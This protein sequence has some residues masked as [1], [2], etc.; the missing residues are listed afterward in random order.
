MSELKGLVKRVRKIMRKDVVSGDA[1]RIE[2]LVWMFF[3]KVYDELKESNEYELE[4]SDYKS[5]IPEKYRWRNWAIDHKDGKA[6]TGDELVS[7]INN[8]LFPALKDLHVD[9]NTPKRS[10]IVQYVFSRLHNYM[11]NGTLI[12]QVLNEL[13][14]NIDFDKYEDRHLFNEIYESILQELQNAG[15][16]GEFYTPRPI[17]DFMAEI[18]DPKPGEIIADFAC[19]TGGFLVSAINHMKKNNNSQHA[20]DSIQENVIGCEFKPLP[21]LLCVTNMLLHDLDG[22]NITY[23]SSLSRN[24]YDYGPNDQVDVVLMNPPFGGEIAPGE[25]LNFPKLYR[26]SETANLFICL[27]LYRL[28][29]EGR[30]AIVLPDS[31]LTT[32]SEQAYV[33]LKKKLMKECNLHTIV[34]LPTGLF[35]AN[36]ATNILFFE[37]GKETNGIWY[38]KVPLPEGYRSFSKT[39]P[40]TNEHLNGVRKWWNNRENGDINA[41]FVTQQQI[42]DNNYNIDIKNPNIKDDKP[43][44]SAEQLMS[45]IGDNLGKR[46]EAFGRIQNALKNNVYFLNEEKVE[47]LNNDFDY[48]HMLRLKVIEHFMFDEEKTDKWE[49]D[50]FVNACSILDS[51]RKPITKSDRKKGEYPYY[52][53]NGIQDYVDGYLFDGEF[54]LIGEDGSVITED[55]KPIV[56]LASGKIWVNNHAHIV[57]ENG[58]CLLKYLYYYL[59]NV[60]ITKYAHGNIPKFTQGDLKQLVIKYP[61]SLSEQREIIQKIAYIDYLIDIM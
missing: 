47:K 45:I 44:Y 54:L 39:K 1:Q 48:K 38:Y 22:S 7:F 32:N 21:Y 30:V 28:K 52:G 17:T 26:T 6:L 34:R 25:D 33:E 36:I 10:A 41:Y 55:G 51:R 13:N 27:V 53:A 18:M 11:V 46:N 23:G 31:F 35:Y 42:I 2:Q 40:F 50:T 49:S 43:E 14:E 29:K 8:E 19:G 56:N 5:I 9:E 57:E 60:D 4:S 16:A 3:L 15:S 59:Q 61:K 37:K 20:L 58:K 12:R 24:V